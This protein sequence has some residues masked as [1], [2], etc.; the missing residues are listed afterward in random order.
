MQ[1]QLSDQFKY[2]N[3][4]RYFKKSHTIELNMDL[5]ILEIFY[6]DI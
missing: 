1:F 6:Q 3:V 5:N 2:L 4:A